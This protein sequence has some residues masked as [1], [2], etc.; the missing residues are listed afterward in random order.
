VILR[1]GPSTFFGQLAHDIA[2]RHIPTAFDQGINRFTW[3]MVRFILVMV[4]TVFL[5]NGC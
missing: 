2:G 4:P 1:T 5:I 3:L